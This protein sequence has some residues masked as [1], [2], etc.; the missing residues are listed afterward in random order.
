MSALSIA[1]ASPRRP[2][3]NSGNDVTAERWAGRL[4]ELG[5]RVVVVPVTDGTDDPPVPSPADLLSEV[6]GLVALHA[7]RSSAPV[8]WWHTNRSDSPLIV[9]LT[10]TDLYRDMPDDPSAMASAD[11]ADRLVVLQEA[12]IDR[13]A[14]FDPALAAKAV[15]IPQSVAPPLP[16]AAPTS[17]EFRVVV[18]AHLREVKDPLMAARAAR[19]LSPHSRI[20]VH[21]A[22]DAHDDEW[23]QQA[24]DEEAANPRFRWHRGL[25]RSKALSL[26]ASG[27][28]LACTSLLEGG[29]NAVSEAIA[30]GVPVVGTEIDGNR[31]MLGADYPGLVPVGDDQSLSALL[32]R[33]EGEGDALDDLRRRTAA[34]R[35]STR[36]DVER[37]AWSTLLSEL[38]PGPSETR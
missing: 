33:L 21:L 30:I 2:A 36:P 9:C 18:L 15:A 11:A 26:L 38:F 28:L 24:V 12:A 14:G 5:H 34:L 1:I 7:R 19:H 27:H 13:L 22:G 10:G 31:G 20:M 25:A 32:I 8:S 37:S 4:R 16:P 6:D 23:H 35:P 17:D 3:R 29:A